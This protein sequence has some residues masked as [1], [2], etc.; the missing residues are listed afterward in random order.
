M[1]IIKYY[2]AAFTFGIEIVTFTPMQVEQRKQNVGYDPDFDVLFMVIPYPA[3]WEKNNQKI[4]NPGSVGQPRDR[5]SG[6]LGHFGKQ[7]PK[8]VTF[9]E[10]KVI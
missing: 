10:K 4:I 2:Y 3:I 1:I 7:K 8:D 5:G 9:L 6:H